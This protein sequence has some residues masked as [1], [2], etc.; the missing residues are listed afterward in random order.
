MGWCHSRRSLFIK[1]QEKDWSKISA[2][3]KNPRTGFIIIFPSGTIG[4]RASKLGH[5]ARM[6][7]GHVVHGAR[8][9]VLSA[10]RLFSLPGLRSNCGSRFGKQIGKTWQWINP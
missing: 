10:I 3:P 7:H 8:L 2:H 4:F 6:L 9:G 1:K 5:I